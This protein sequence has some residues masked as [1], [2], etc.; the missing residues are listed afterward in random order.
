MTAGGVSLLYGEVEAT[1]I[2]LAYRD[3]LTAISE[4]LLR[5]ET[6]GESPV[7]ERDHILVLG[8]AILVTR[9]MCTVSWNSGRTVTT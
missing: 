3:S 4:I 9:P 6:L 1:D 5:R 2:L 8:F 7:A